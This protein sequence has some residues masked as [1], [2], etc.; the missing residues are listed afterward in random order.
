MLMATE[1][2]GAVG[3]GVTAP[4]FFR[5][6]DGKIYVVKFQNNQLGSR[7]LASEF[8]AVQFGEIMNLCFPPSGI[9][10]I[11][12]QM[13]QESPS[14]MELGVNPGRHFASQYLEH[15]QYLGK[16]NLSKAV[17]VAEM[18][19]VMLFDHIFH[20]SDRTNNKKNL[21]IRREEAGYKIYAIDN[22][23]LFGSGRWT[24][25]S[26]THLATKIRVYYRYSYG[27]LLRDRLS[28]EDFLPY[29]E[30]VT[31]LS[32]EHIETIV[33]EIP[34]EWLPDEPERQGLIHYIKT[35]RDMVEDIW[36]IL[37]KYIPRSRG[38]RRWL[39]G[40]AIKVSEKL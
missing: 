11:N 33:R 5:A 18:A 9:I 39:F 17:N 6:D 32:D 26:V 15:T 38:G 35:R 3:V 7:V 34:E 24:L 28:P 40:K 8:L 1:H 21:L 29:L 30:K 10:G 12:E 31:E 36:K 13:L 27:L 22:S 20:N 23:H 37:C 16:H 25:E 19:G 2:L 14:L 4:Q